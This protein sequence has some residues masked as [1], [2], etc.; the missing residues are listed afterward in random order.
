MKTTQ[1]I[2]TSNLITVSKNVS[3]KEAFSVMKTNGIR[4]LPV[5]DEKSK[6][7]GILSDRDIQRAMSV[8]KLGP[9]Q[10]DVTL[11]ESLKVEDF[12]S[13]PVYMV[14]E[15]TSIERVAEEMLA[16]KISAFIV[17]DRHDK[18]KGIITTDDLLGYL[19]NLIKADGPQKKFQPLSWF[20]FQQPN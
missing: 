2:M 10:Q 5:K 12:M 13:W 18:E 8:K 9:F 7:I 17:V 1:T 6:I 20:Q 16:Q 3:V 19:L 4:H 14:S 15:E 11:D